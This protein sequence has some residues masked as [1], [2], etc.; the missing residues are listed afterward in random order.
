MSTSSENLELQN[1][2]TIL[3]IPFIISPSEA[4]AECAFL[5][6]HNLVDGIIT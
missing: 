5:E 2:L 4:E 1:L 3:G 6:Q